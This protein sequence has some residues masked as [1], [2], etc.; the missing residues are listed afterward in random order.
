MYMYIC[1]RAIVL[2]THI[3]VHVYLYMCVSNSSVYT[4][5][6]VHMCEQDV[7]WNS[8]YCPGALVSQFHSVMTHTTAVNRTTVKIILI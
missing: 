7:L 3:H 8:L 1:L 4:Y 6:H 2:Y 5:I